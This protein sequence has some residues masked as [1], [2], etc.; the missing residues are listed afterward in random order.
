VQQ[1]L[2]T[3]LSSSMQIKSKRL[4]MEEQVDDTQES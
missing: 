4:S 2:P 3:L 1:R